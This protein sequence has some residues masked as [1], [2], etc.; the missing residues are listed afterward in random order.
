MVDDTYGSCN[1]SSDKVWRNI[2]PDRR[3]FN[4]YGCNFYPVS[5]LLR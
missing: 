1:F 4:L 2:N 5:V 3:I